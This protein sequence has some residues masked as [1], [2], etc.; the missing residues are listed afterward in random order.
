M[1]ADTAALAALAA[2]YHDF[3]QRT[4]PT[5]A[6]MEGDYR[7]AETFEQV[8][9][10][11]EDR[12]AGEGRAFAR[13][14]EA[15]PETGMGSQDR[16]S[17]AMLAWDAAIHA[18]RAASRMT[19]FSA[20]PISGPQSMLPVY[21]PKMS[22]PTAEVAEAMIP[23]Y[24]GMARMFRDLG[25]RHREGLAADRT[26]PAFAVEQVVTQIDRWLSTPLAADPLLVLG[27]TPGLADREAWLGRLRDVVEHEVRP[28]LASYGEILREEILPYSRPD[29]RPGLTWLPGGDEMYALAVRFYTTTA[30]T[31]QE[32]HEVGLQ[33]IAS[34]ADEYRALGPAVMGTDDL[35]RILEGLRSDP[36][37]H[38][39]DAGEIV[40]ASRA[41]LA[42]AKA[43]MP[44]WFGILPQ[45]DCAVEA[46]TSG[47]IAYY[48]PPAIDGSRGGTFFMN[49]SQPSDWG[50]YQIEA[51]SYHE[52]IPGHHLQVAIAQE[53]QGVPEFRKHAWIAAY[54]EGWGL[55]SE[56][57]ADEMGIYSSPLDRMGM[58]EADSMRACRLVVDTGMHA[59]GWSRRRAIDFMLENSPMREGH[60]TAEIDRYAVNPGQALAYMIGRLEIQ[61]I[62]AAAEKT[63]GPR[64]DIRAFHDTV[65]DS[66][67]MPLPMLERLVADWAAARAA[68]DR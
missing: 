34:L 4:N 7:F 20:S 33:Q 26:P 9:R 2:E 64:F 43:A 60:V 66:G 8:S 30:M 16:L 41:A 50:R 49:T 32:V 19:E 45:A 48:F 10:E 11:A 5:S 1:A 25:E 67:L 12:E 44:G 22:L 29:D 56:R 35:P 55:Y 51:T 42:R 62:R 27:P 54:G 52:G 24:R 61:R 18:D 23:K 28:A 14:A 6:H 13:R 3:N 38:H 47:A 59:F 21:M 63:L 40:A 37:L 39:T 31:A 15:I 36:A 57:L 17:R 65:L 68:A 58:L 53:L 46:T